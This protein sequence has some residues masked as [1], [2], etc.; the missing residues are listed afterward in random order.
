MQYRVI[1]YKKQR[2]RNRATSVP[3]I[4]LCSMG[5][6]SGLHGKHV[7]VR[8]AP[9]A[10]LARRQLSRTHPL[11]AEGRQAQQ[12]L[13]KD[14]SSFTLFTFFYFLSRR[15][16]K[17]HETNSLRFLIKR[18]TWGFPPLTVSVIPITLFPELNP[19][20]KIQNLTSCYSLT[21]CKDF[22]QMSS[23]VRGQIVSFKLHMWMCQRPVP[24]NVITFG[25][26][27]FTGVVKLKEV[28]QGGAIIQ[29]YCVLIRFCYEGLEYLSPI[30]LII[31]FSC[32]LRWQ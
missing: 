17:S 30:G 28:Y 19:N 2:M 10:G 9:L 5:P 24:Q 13:F 8:K 31:F 7:K 4:S 21:F 12:Q 16:P 14:A 1:N 27:V 20:R 22:F 11:E 25:G 29:Y 18:E 15:G 3:C 26:E 6:A 23:F 32:Y